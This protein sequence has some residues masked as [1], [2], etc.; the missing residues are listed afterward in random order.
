MAR[1]R[2]PHHSPSSLTDYAKCGERF[3]RKRIEGESEPSTVNQLRGRG[4]HFGIY[5]NNVQKIKTHEDLPKADIVEIAVESFKAETRTNE[6]AFTDDEWSIGATATIREATNTVV[7][8][9][10]L[11]A[12]ELAPKYQ[13][14]LAEKWVTIELPNSTH[15]LVCILD[16]V[17]DDRRIVDFKTGK[18]QNA[19]NAETSIQLTTQSLAY[20]REFGE[21]PESVTL[22]TMVN[23]ITP[24]VQTLTAYRDESDVAAL[25]ARM[26]V[27]MAAIE[28]GI[29]PP[30]ADGAWWCSPNYCG[31]YATCR[32]VNAARRKA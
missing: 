16:M 25:A 4:A 3:R 23:N 12:D 9:A 32:Y 8:L 19:A 10:E 27:T 17:T 1:K 31:F 2:K 15:D 22:E 14:I 7:S 11:Y 20:H 24:V 13:P 6:I 28:A 21:F 18:R 29:F 26:S 30:A 5:E